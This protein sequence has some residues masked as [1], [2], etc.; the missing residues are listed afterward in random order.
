M[1]CKVPRRLSFL[2]ADRLGGR[3]IQ[4]YS[5]CSG[6]FGFAERCLT[7]PREAIF[8][9]QQLT[10]LTQIKSADVVAEMKGLSFRH[11]LL[12]IV[13]FAAP[14]FSTMGRK[15]ARGVVVPQQNPNAT[16]THMVLCRCLECVMR[17]PNHRH[18]TIGITEARSLMHTGLGGIGR[19]FPTEAGP[20]WDELW[21]RRPYPWDP[22]AAAPVL[23]LPAAGAAAAAA[24]D[25]SGDDAQPMDADDAA[26]NQPH[27]PHG[28]P[29]GAP[30]NNQ[31]HPPHGPQPGAPP[32]ANMPAAPAGVYTCV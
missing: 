19:A 10:S 9:T 28:P 2:C 11:G 13:C 23:P 25:G 17:H 6:S 12:L 5:L 15:Q 27:P 29:Q 16:L 18:Q 7:F 14:V 24:A 1:V 20:G 26:N 21:D 22:V 32:A 4:R 31:P 30:G 3:V 8:S